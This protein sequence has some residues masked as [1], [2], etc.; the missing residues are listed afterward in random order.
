MSIN[1]YTTLVFLGPK[2]QQ[3]CN[4]RKNIDR[5]ELLIL[6]KKSGTIKSKEGLAQMGVANGPISHKNK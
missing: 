5:S 2:T 4:A 1:N 6:L 3:S